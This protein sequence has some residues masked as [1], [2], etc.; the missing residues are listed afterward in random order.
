MDKDN[1]GMLIAALRKERFDPVVGKVWSQARL[2]RETGLT[3]KVIGDIER[4]SRSTLD[5]DIVVRLAEAF[6]LNTM[7]RAEFFSLSSEVKQHVVPATYNPNAF[8]DCVALL[9][10]LQLPA[11]LQDSFYNL[12]AVN[13]SWC[14]FY[15]VPDNFWRQ[16]ED[17]ANY[18]FIRMMID[19]QAN[20][21][22]IMGAQYRRS[23]DTAV[24]LFRWKTLPYRHT[25]Y[26]SRL[27]SQ[28]MEL[29]GFGQSWMSTQY[30]QQDMRTSIK[31]IDAPHP[32]Y[33]RTVYNVAKTR[34]VTS[35][36]PI[37]YSM[38]LPCSPD[39][40]SVFQELSR[41]GGAQAI[42][43]SPFPVWEPN[44]SRATDE[45]ARLFSARASTVGRKVQP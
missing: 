1:F 18:N 42:P 41:N 31:A 26:Y 11:S 21:R 7:E 17:C 43:L 12:L 23:V 16:E 28:L 5:A 27:F 30:I 14:R 9:Q 33:G 45:V 39:T 4:G 36:G 2:A 15:E 32:V 34:I 40:A 8:N 37:Y 35:Y 22:R 13:R 6:A 44:A 3:E 38:L 29:P 19:P 25:D 10:S 20:M 24:G